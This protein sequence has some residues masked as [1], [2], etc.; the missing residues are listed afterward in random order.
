MDNQKNTNVLAI[1]GLIAGILSIFG[2][3]FA[4]VGC[5][6]GIVGLVCSILSRKQGPS[7]MSVAGI[8]CSIIGIVGG[9]IMTIFAASLLVAL[10]DAGYSVY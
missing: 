4:W 1:I 8:V 6:I 9:I 7:G 10:Q 5:V 3:C 2:I